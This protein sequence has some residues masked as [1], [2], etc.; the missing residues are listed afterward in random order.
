MIVNAR[1]V[2]ARKSV[3]TLVVIMLDEFRDGVV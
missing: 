2:V 3:V 1:V